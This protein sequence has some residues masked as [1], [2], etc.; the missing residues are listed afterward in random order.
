MSSLNEPM[1]AM[2][3]LT[4]RMEFADGRVCECDVPQPIRP[5]MTLDLADRMSIGPFD[6]SPVMIQLPPAR[7]VKL[8]FEANPRA[9]PLLR[10]RQVAP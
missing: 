10:W 6:P 2:I 3:R 4:V 5:S 9:D 1:P 7:R 8:E